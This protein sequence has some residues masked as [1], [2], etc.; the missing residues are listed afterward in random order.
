MYQ[1]SEKRKAPP[2]RLTKLL[3]DATLFQYL[4]AKQTG[5]KPQFKFDPVSMSSEA[6]L[7]KDLISTENQNKFSNQNL[8]ELKISYHTRGIQSQYFRLSSAEGSAASG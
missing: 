6:S 2:N 4:A 1:I 5:S 7:L 3:K 8:N